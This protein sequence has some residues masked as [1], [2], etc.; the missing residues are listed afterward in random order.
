MLEVISPSICLPSELQYLIIE[1]M[2]DIDRGCLW[3]TSFVCKDWRVC[4]YQRAFTT[5]FLSRRSIPA[6]ASFLENTFSRLAIFS[7]IR[8]IHILGDGETFHSSQGQRNGLL[9]I[10]RYL[11][12]IGNISDL[13]VENFD[14]AVLDPAIAV[15]LE[16][17]KPIGR[18]SIHRAFFTNF[19]QF[20]D[21][22][23]R[24]YSLRAFDFQSIECS[25]PHWDTG[26][27]GKSCARDDS[28][29]CSVS[30]YGA[31]RMLDKK[32]T[33]VY[34]KYASQEAKQMLSFYGAQ[35][36][37]N[38]TDASGLLRTLGPLLRRLE[39]VSPENAVADAIIASLDVSM[40]SSLQYLHLSSPNRVITL[41]SWLPSILLKITSSNLKRLHISF[42]QTRQIHLDRPFLKEVAKILERPQF[43]ELELIEFNITGSGRVNLEGVAKGKIIDCIR[44]CLPSWDKRGILAFAFPSVNRELQPLFNKIYSIVLWQLEAHLRVLIGITISAI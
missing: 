40:N 28:G 37:C 31:S 4:S 5:V 9:K 26:L 20:S 19:F 11:A 22:V 2:I 8:R 29:Q 39:I 21:F 7:G 33:W 6:L 24:F 25:A 18:L 27:S 13:V 38:S 43:Q 12:Q 1:S 17:L 41:I 10:L 34:S 36:S 42:S 30:F 44:S 3:A 23:A 32:L 16:L 15:S 14:W 35:T